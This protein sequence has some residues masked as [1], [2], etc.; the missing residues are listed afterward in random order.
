MTEREPIEVNFRDG[1]PDG[2]RAVYDK[3][4][5]MVFT[6]A[7]RS[8]GSAVDAEDVTQQVFIRAWH[9]RSTYDPDR[10]PIAAWLIGI[11]RHAI[12][13]A[14]AGRSRQHPGGNP[15]PLGDVAETGGPDPTDRV[16]D[17]VVLTQALTDLGPPQ[18]DILALAFFGRLTHTE[19]AERLDM[20][21][22]TVKSHITRG[23][24]QLRT[25][26]GGHDAAH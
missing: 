13:D 26:V 12:A 5:P 17:H 11:T 14:H 9:S 21:L 16:V 1:T 19:I 7:L 20:P 24:K 18:S 8:L 22:G 4:S 3:H 15:A 10:A 6:L 25:R 2:V 23:L